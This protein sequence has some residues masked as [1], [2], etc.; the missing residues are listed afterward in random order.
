MEA[1]NNKQEVV[2]R[3]K[4]EN[5]TSEEDEKNKSQVNK[6]LLKNRKMA[7]IKNY[8]LQQNI[9]LSSKSRDH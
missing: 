5:K 2:I 8:I 3:R 7:F 4:Q 6:G 9:I 1:S